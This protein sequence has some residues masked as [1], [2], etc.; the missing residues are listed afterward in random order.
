MTEQ[1]CLNA[2]ARQRLPVGTRCVG[3]GPSLDMIARR[4]SRES[5]EAAYEAPAGRFMTPHK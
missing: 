4:L 5:F 1:R 2:L 3:E